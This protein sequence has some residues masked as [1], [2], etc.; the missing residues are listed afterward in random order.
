TC[1][2][3]RNPVGTRA[4]VTCPIPRRIA[5]PALRRIAAYT[6]P[7]SN[8]FTK[9][10][11]RQCEDK[12]MRQPFR[13]DGAPPLLLRCALLLC[14]VCFRPRVAHAGCVTP[15]PFGQLDP[16]CAGT[17]CY[18]VSPGAHTYQSFAGSFWA[19]GFGDPAVG[20]GVDNGSFEPAQG[21]LSSYAGN[22]FL[23]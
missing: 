17:Y 13:S 9:A 8:G 4:A 21:W 6:P 23:Y 1:L 16:A 14:C 10:V 22:Y 5:R 11:P 3:S 12:V 19:L 20:K 7:S 15:V 2:V 18:V